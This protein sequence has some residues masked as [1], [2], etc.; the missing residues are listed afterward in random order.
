MLKGLLVSA[1]VLAPGFVGAQSTRE[2]IDQAIALYEAFNVEAARPILQ[3]IISPGYT[4]QVSSQ[5]KAVALKYLGASYAVLEKPDSA[6]QFFMGAL[7][8]DPFTDLDPTKFAASELG[9]F[10]EAKRRL[11][12]V[13]IRP[14]AGPALVSRDS[15]TGVR[16]EFI[17]T[18]R[19]QIRIE[20]IN[21]RDTSIKEML[22]EGPNEGV[23]PVAW[24]GVLQSG[25]YAPADIYQLRIRGTPSGGSNTLTETASLRIEHIFEPLEDTLP[26][27]DP[28]RDLLP[29][30]IRSSQPW[31]DLAKGAALA[32]AAITIPVLALEKNDIAWA[33]HAGVTAF[34]GASSATISF[35]YRRNRPQIRA[36]VLENTRRRT[37]RDNFN[38]AVRQRNQARLGRT[39]LIVSPVTFGQ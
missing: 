16:F 30:R 28:A 19:S 39:L 9:A 32:A 13:A 2:R 11:F 15:A 21:Q 18:Q 29:E 35:W 23:R 14:L 38:A 3:L 6:V 26:S 8:F 5:E 25:R 34:V 7:D 22:Y 1:A 27:L 33:P 31:Y 4:Q 10:N 17:T 24:R 20:I 36:N 12:K 37:L